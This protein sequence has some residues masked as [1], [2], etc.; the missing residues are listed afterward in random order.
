MKLIDTLLQIFGRTASGRTDTAL[1]G[2]AAHGITTESG[3]RQ[4]PESRLRA[5]YA[6]LT[7]IDHEHRATVL[8][9]RAMDRSDG[10]VKRIHNRTARDVVRGG[11]V[12]QQN[13]P[14]TRIEREWNAFVARLQLNR[15][16]KL[17][18]DA[19]GLITEGNL[20]YQWVLDPEGN[21]I[22][23]VRMPSETMR[24][25]VGADGRFADVRQAYSQIDVMTGQPLAHFPLWQLT[26][27]RLDPDNFDDMASLGRPFLDASREIWR[28]LRMTDT[29]LVIRRRHRAPLRISHILEGATDGDLTAY[30]ARTEQNKD[31]ITTDFYSNKKGSITAMQ[32]DAALDQIADVTYLLDSF[33]AGTPLAKGMAGYADGLS[34][35]ILE[36]LK[37]DYYDEV[38]LLQDTVAAVYAMGFRLQLLLRGINPD[39]NA[40]TITFRERRTESLTQ[41]V[42]R[43]LK[44][45]AAGIPDPM[46][47]EELGYNA[48]TVER[49]RADWIKR[50]D[51]YPDDEEHGDEHEPAAPV[52]KITPGNGRKGE[53]ATDI[54]GNG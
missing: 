50:Y 8:D 21:V 48:D 45:K 35:D 26:I 34:R 47:Y 20:A 11:L 43:A 27:G 12:L 37:R 24:P 14:S 2:E 54:G 40:Y 32:G 13:N 6:E 41:T 25:N 16:D 36:D 4:T 1:P 3:S 49:R 29:D 15:P 51:P 38:D 44:L 39:A 28:K 22:A 31:L 52:V 33:F 46:V 10:R 9:I 23:G 7:T 17:K 42:D 5:L 18:S 19:R 30:K 53:S